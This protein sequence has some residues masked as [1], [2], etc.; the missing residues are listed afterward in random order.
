MIKNYLFE[1]VIR[2]AGILNSVETEYQIETLEALKAS[3]PKRIASVIKV[4]HVEWK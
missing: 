4:A 2:A 3:Q 1:K